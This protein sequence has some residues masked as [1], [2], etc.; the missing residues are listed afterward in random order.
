MLRLDPGVTGDLYSVERTLACA[1]SRRARDAM[2]AGGEG[3]AERG[4]GAGPT[5]VPW[6]ARV[7]CGDSRTG[8]VVTE[9]AAVVTW[10]GY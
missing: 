5:L 2:D 10:S 8:R 6:S 9:A 1:G 7:V 4:S 3:Q